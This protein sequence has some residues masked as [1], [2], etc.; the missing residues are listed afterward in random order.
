MTKILAT[1]TLIVLV[2][3]TTTI[4]AQTAEEVAQMKSE[5]ASK[6]EEAAK[7]KAELDAIN[8][9]IAT[10][11]SAIDK[12][13]KWRFGSGGLLGFDI[14]NF[15]NW[16]PKPDLN[17][18]AQSISFNYNGFANLIE[19][20]Y[21]W[22]SNGGVNLGWQKYDEDSQTTGDNDG[23]DQVA[24]VLFLQ[25]L[26]GYNF[27]KEIAGS[28]LGEYRSTLL[29]NFN[30][31]GFLDIG[32][33][34]TYTPNSKFFM[35][36]HPLNYNFIFAENETD[37]TSSLG[38]KLVAD[39]NTKLYDLLS[40]RSNLSAFLSY[41]TFE[42]SNYTWV[43]SFNFVAF[44]GIGIGFE[45]GLRWNPQETLARGLASDNQS[46]YQLGLSYAIQ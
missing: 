6:A 27:T 12:T 20:K 45:L 4:Q 37:Y 40:W 25:S 35:V 41:D 23:F 30:N 7:I 39:Y 43:N 3:I 5:M 26:F 42:Q 38:A 11:K 24:D 34:I 8:G 22:R 15:N 44:K 2:G 33:G 9:E 1:L 31:P 32:V 29:S 18:S 28:A 46:Y 16:A 14:N 13:I 17:S 19:E 21:F 10:L 36:L